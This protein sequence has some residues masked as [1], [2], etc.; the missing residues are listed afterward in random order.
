MESRLRVLCIQEQAA[1]R[2]LIGD[3][4]TAL[5]YLA[6]H[7]YEPG[8]VNGQSNRHTNGRISKNEEGGWSVRSRWDLEGSEKGESPRDTPRILNR[9]L[10]RERA[11][12]E[13]KMWI[14]P[15]DLRDNPVMESKLDQ[16]NSKLK[17]L[18]EHIHSL[19]NA[20]NENTKLKVKHKEDEKLW[21]GLESKFFS[22][23]TLCH[24]LTETLQ[25]LSDQTCAQ[26]LTMKRLRGYEIKG[27]GTKPTYNRHSQMEINDDSAEETSVPDMR[28]HFET[29]IK[30]GPGV[31]KQ[32][33]VSNCHQI[34]YGKNINHNSRPP[35]FNYKDRVESLTS[36]LTVKRGEFVEMD[37]RGMSRKTPKK[38]LASDN[39]QT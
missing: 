9:D 12:A 37:E 18:S 1:A 35:K 28:D 3:V 23:K 16:L 10:D 13:A 22:T 7:V 21:K 11:V 4:V 39:P 29:S 19:Q 8:A 17:N 25:L 2:P 36:D 20:Y 31:R 27:Q 26:N 24:Q 15:H 34:G 30:H 32:D 38:A 5:S 6:N 33:S 14:L